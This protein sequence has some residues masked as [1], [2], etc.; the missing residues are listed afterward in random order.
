MHRAALASGT[1][2]LATGSD[3]GGSLRIPA[4]FCSVY[5][6]R[7]SPGRVPK[8]ETPSGPLVALHSIGGPMARTVSDLAIFL[9]AMV[10]L[11]TERQLGWDFDAPYNLPEGAQCYADVVSPAVY[12]TLLPARVAWSPDLN[13]LITSLVESET[14][15][16]CEAAAQWF[17]TIYVFFF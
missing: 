7:V 12:P 17:G 2:W 11:G 16:M 8:P 10:D 13:G 9:D 15:S 3:L 5:G 4:S 1:A 14:L 6:F